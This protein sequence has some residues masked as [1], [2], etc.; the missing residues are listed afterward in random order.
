MKIYVKHRRAQNRIMPGRRRLAAGV[1]AAVSGV[2]LGVGAGAVPAVAV[3]AAPAV[4]VKAAVPKGL[5]SFYGQRV[6]WYDCGATGGME[7]SA[8]ATAFKCAKVKVPLD[9]S[10]PDGQTIEIAMKKHVATG[11]IHRGSLFINPG[12][13]GGSGVQYVEAAAETSF[14]G[15]QGSYDIIGFDPRGVGSSTPITCAAANDAAAT[16]AAGVGAPQADTPPSPVDGGA[17]NDYK[18]KSPE[19][20]AAASGT[21]FEDA[22]PRIAEEYKQVEAQC[23]ANTKPAGLLDHVDTVSAVRDLDILRALSGNEKLDYAG[24]SYGT[25]LGAHYAELFPSNTG[26]MVLDGAMDPSLTLYESRRGQVIG[27]EHSLRT[28]VEWCQGAADC[29]LSGGTD[30]GV[31][32]ISDLFSSAD[33]SPLP[34]SDPNRSVTGTDI[35]GVVTQYMYFSEQDWPVL[36]QALTQ[37]IVHH[38][39][40]MIRSILDRFQSAGSNSTLARLAINCLDYQVEGDMTSWAARDQEMEQVAPHFGQMAVISDLACQSWGHTGTQPPKALHA[41]GAAP[42]LVIGTTGDPATPYEW[43]KALAGQLESG[44]LLTWEGNGHTAYANAGHGPCITKA[45]DTYLLT[46]TMPKKD[47]T[48]RGKE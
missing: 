24:F 14:A 48:C 6:E 9:Y 22:A 27:F 8:E 39:G 46:G 21:S 18:E 7:K 1:L 19:V 12:G 35:K 2:C 41:K 37:A 10:Q 4:A 33:Q 3:P 28:Y 47:L 5:E 31:Q 44:Q 32:Q 40:S 45:V 43:A 26:R 16:P 20:D 30:A 42:I 13:P 23:A 15:V 11:S 36:N 29:P 34:T 25:Y 38:D 17:N